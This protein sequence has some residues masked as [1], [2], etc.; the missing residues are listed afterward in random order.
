MSAKR[1][2]EVGQ[3]FYPKNSV[4]SRYSFRRVVGIVNDRVF[5]SVGAEKIFNCSRASFISA[6]S[7]SINDDGHWISKERAAVFKNGGIH[8]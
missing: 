6:T 7:D 8:A 5:Y 2:I 3:V 4:G 1:K